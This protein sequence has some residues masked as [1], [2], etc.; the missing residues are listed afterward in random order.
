MGAISFWKP[1]RSG[2]AW[3]GS[4]FVCFLRYMEDWVP[5]FFISSSAGFSL[6]LTVNV[7]ARNVRMILKTDG[8]I[9]GNYMIRHGYVYEKE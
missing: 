4:I 5:S 2:L 9:L 3:V 7:R 8:F 6:A 1:M